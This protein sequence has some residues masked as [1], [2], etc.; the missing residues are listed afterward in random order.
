MHCECPLS[1][2]KRTS[3][4]QPSSAKRAI[5]HSAL[6]WGIA[7]PVRAM[8]AALRGRVRAGAEGKAE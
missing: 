2:V 8:I 4:A 6:L 7:V 3:L 5:K 1:G